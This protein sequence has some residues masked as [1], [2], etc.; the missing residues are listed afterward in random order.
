MNLYK[1]ALSRGGSTVDGTS[2]AEQ[3]NAI[4]KVSRVY[5]ERVN[6]FTVV[7]FLLETGEN[8]IVSTETVPLAIYIEPGDTVSILYLATGEQ[9]LPVKDLRITGLPVK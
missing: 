5:K 7:S 3:A 9:F 4:G 2:N 1:T 8:F 6:D